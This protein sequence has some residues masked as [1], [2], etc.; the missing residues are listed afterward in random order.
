MAPRE[1]GVLHRAEPEEPASGAGA[2]GEDETEDEIED[3]EEDD[4]DADGEE[5]M[6]ACTPLVLS[7]NDSGALAK[8]V[9]SLEVI[10]AHTM[11]KCILLVEVPE[12][13]AAALE[14]RPPMQGG[15][16]GKAKGGRGKSDGADADAD[17][18]ADAADA[19]A[20]GDEGAVEAADTRS[21]LQRVRAQLEGASVWSNASANHVVV[22]ALDAATAEHGKDL[23][24]AAVAADARRTATV[25]LEDSL[26]GGFVGKGGKVVQALQQRTGCR[27]DIRRGASVRRG[28]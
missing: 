23:V 14:E 27:I 7:S 17:A 28:G 21:P 24:L 10:L 1:V 8:G 26:L 25:M 15:K 20:D 18:D 3:V 19:D 2:D 5:G 4:G 9:H 16:G 6:P 12:G 11:G 22:C 13:A